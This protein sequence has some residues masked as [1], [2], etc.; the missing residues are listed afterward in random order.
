MAVQCLYGIKLIHDYGF[1]HRD[2]K[3]NNFVM[4]HPADPERAWMVHILDFGM[5][6]VYATKKANGL[7]VARKARP[8]AE[9]RGT[10]RYCSPN[11][12]L[13]VEQGRRDDLW[14][15]L[16]MLIEIHCG[17]PWQ[18]DDRP[19]IRKKKLNISDDSLMRHMP[20][21]CRHL[22]AGLRAFDCYSRPNYSSVFSLF[23]Y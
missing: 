13:K 3:L 14:G 12:H 17:L 6:R 21:E 7:W 11:A 5:V 1:V 20:E 4:G 19:Q 15:L 2:I 22:P 8:S 18:T 16:Y 10:Y 23:L 9:I